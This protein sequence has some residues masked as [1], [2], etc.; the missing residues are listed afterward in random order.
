MAHHEGT[1]AV[2]FVVTA[3]DFTD[4]EALERRLAH[5]AKHLLGMQHLVER[6]N[7]LSGGAI[8]DDAGRMVGSTA[9]VRFDSKDLVEN[10]IERDPYTLGRVW[11]TVEIRQVRLLDVPGSAEVQSP[12]PQAVQSKNRTSVRAARITP[13]LIEDAPL[14]N[15][16]GVHQPHTPRAIIEVETED[17]T[18]GLGETY[19]DMDYLQVLQMFAERL[20]G[21]S[22]LEPNSLWNLAEEAIRP[23]TVPSDL[24]DNQPAHSVFGIK[25]LR[26]LRATIVSAFEVAFLDATGR[27]LGVPVHSLLGGKVRDRIDFAA[28]LFYRWDTHPFADAPA[29]GWGAALDG[30]A[31]VKQATRMIEQYGFRSLKLKGGVFPPEQEIAAVKALHDAFPAVPVRL[32]PNGAWSLET[33]IRVAEEL[34]DI[35]E[36]LE[37][38]CMGQE[39]MARVHAQTGVPLATNMCVTYMDEIPEAIQLDSVQVLLTDHHYW[40]G[41]RATQELSAICETFGLGLS[42]HSNSHLGISLAAMIHAAACVSGNLHACD[43]HRPWQTEDVITSPHRFFDGA[44]VVS[45]EPGLGIELDRDS[46]ARLHK[47]WL[48]SEVRNRDDVAAM[49]VADASWTR[50]PVPR[51]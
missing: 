47:R 37:D 49:R 20:T 2:E 35:V 23:D 15:M 17:G 11:D 30:D 42:M 48:E 26:K 21:R 8:L 28:Y 39:D 32:D 16:Q 43:T 14:L 18:I 31:I 33:S 4:E 1:N 24:I 51:W 22:I 3:R 44:I 34:K 38:P 36:Y 40:G 29:D 45:D 5:R 9:H 41:L 6:G 25:S 7:L 46:L 50:P 12:L 13:I 19:G 10:W 27:V